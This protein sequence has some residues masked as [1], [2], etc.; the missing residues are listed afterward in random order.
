MLLDGNSLLKCDLKFNFSKIFKLNKN[1]TQWVPKI[2]FQIIFC[3]NKNFRIPLMPV[4]E[5]EVSRFGSTATVRLDFF[6][7]FPFSSPRWCFTTFVLLGRRGVSTEEFGK[8]DSD[9]LAFDFCIRSRLHTRWMRLE[10]SLPFPF[11]RLRVL[12][13]EDFDSLLLVAIV[14][15]FMR[16]VISDDEAD[17][18]FD[19]AVRGKLSMDDCD[20]AKF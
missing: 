18:T 20:D 13:V 9:E 1:F 11:S 2:F 19:A 8:S 7:S 12:A 17:E 5:C 6:S 14:P 10:A 15:R 16:V 4:V 3:P